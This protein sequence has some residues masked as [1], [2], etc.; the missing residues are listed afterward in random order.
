MNYIT[1]DIQKPAPWSLLYADDV[2]LIAESLTEVQSDLTVWQESLERRGMRVNREKTVYM[3]CNF[4]GVNMDVIPCP[5]IEGG[6]LK[7][8]EEFKYLGSIVAPQACTERDIQNR[9]QTA[10]L[11]WRSLSGILCDSRMP[12][13]IKGNI[14]KRAVRPALLYGSE[15]WPMR[16]TDEQNLH[17][18]EMKMLRWSGGVSRMDK[19]RNYY[20]RGSFKVAMVHKKLRE[21]RMRWYGH[22]MRQDDDHV[23]KKVMNIEE[24][25]KGRGRP[26]ITWLQTLKN[27]LKSINMPETTTHNRTM[28]RKITKRADPN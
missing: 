22:V 27:D 18:T 17:V 19:I 20:T 1:M 26:S 5:S 23:S 13:K 12:I 10:C 14:Y 25:K 3:Y 24:G 8:V 9:T 4:S 6:P 21:N 11:K 7:R 16:K 15:C 28:W 2:V